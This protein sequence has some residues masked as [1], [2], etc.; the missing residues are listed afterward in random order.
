MEYSDESIQAAKNGLEHLCNQVREV[1]KG[2]VAP[3]GP[4]LPRGCPRKLDA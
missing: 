1:A 3:A 2:G 4:C